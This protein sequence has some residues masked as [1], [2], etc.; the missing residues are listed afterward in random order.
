MSLQARQLI[1][2]MPAAFLPQKAGQS[3]V[4]VQFKLDGDGGG[5]WV[6]DVAD[7]NCAVREETLDKPDVTLAM[8]ASDFVALYKN[9]LNPIQAF[10]GGKIQVTGNVGLVMQLLNWF[11]RG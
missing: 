5:A 7:G 8:A 6:L 11:D 3:K 1:E 4:L 10:M 2:A 9:Q